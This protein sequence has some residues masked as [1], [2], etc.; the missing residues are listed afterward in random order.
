MSEI[1]EYKGVPDTQ[2]I[3]DNLINYAC[4][5]CPWNLIEEALNEI[6]RLRAIHNQR[7]G[8][9]AENNVFKNYDDTHIASAPEHLSVLSEIQ[10]RQ[11]VELGLTNTH[12]KS[13]HNERQEIKGPSL[14]ET[15]AVL[16]ADVRRA[17]RLIWGC[18]RE[19]RS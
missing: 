14:D 18:Q 11:R 17:Y 8:M 9:M 16:I 5:D 19:A 7:V 6:D 4:D 15:S 1:P 12:A 13:D 3:R 2:A 10:R